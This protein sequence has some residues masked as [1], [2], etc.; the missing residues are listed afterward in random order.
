MDA[1]V[2][3]SVSALLPVLLLLA[4]SSAPAIDVREALAK[5]ADTYS[6]AAEYEFVVRTTSTAPGSSPF[7]L[8]IAAKRPNRLRMEI[9]VTGFKSNPSANPDDAVTVA[10]GEFMWEY[11]PK[12]RQYSKRTGPASID[13]L[14][15]QWFA[16]FR[17]AAK[18]AGRAR[19]L[20]EESL[21]VG[22][23]SVACWVIEIIDESKSNYYTWWVDKSRYLVLREDLTKGRFQ[24]SAVYTVARVNEALPPGLFVFIPPAGSKH[25]EDPAK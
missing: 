23:S 7:F 25:V 2:R 20:R 12:A 17:N 19:V 1:H 4:Q 3:S 24:E 9:S 14:E 22:G 11:S 15:E 16:R 5:I 21:E 6:S 8:H 18:A 13:R 10:D